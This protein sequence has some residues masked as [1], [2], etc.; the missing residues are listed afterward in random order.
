LVVLTATKFTRSK[1]ADAVIGSEV[2][3]LNSEWTYGSSIRTWSGD[4]HVDCER[5]GD[6][7]W[8]YAARGIIGGASGYVLGHNPGYVEAAED[9]GAG[10]LNAGE[11]IYTFFS[12]AGAWDTLNRAYINAQI[13]A[14]QQVYLS[15]API[16]QEGTGFGMEIQHLVSKGIGPDQWKFVPNWFLY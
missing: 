5:L 9:M 16:G 1:G 11:G 4:D 3:N 7:P 13:F 6:P 15:D 14:N 2:H 12:N 8:S 10:A